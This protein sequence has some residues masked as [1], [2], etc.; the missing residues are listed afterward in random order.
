MSNLQTTTK[1]KNPTGSPSPACPSLWNLLLSLHCLSFPQLS[2]QVSAEGGWLR[3]TAG[4]VPE[5]Y[6]HL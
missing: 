2:Q 3:R 6:R 4:T 1:E 5:G